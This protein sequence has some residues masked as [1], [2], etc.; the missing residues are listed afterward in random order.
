M[1]LLQRLSVMILVLAV[2]ACGAPLGYETG[3]SISTP[4]P[5]PSVRVPKV[6]QEWVYTE[7][8]VYNGKELAIVT[9]RVSSIGTQITITRTIA[10]GSQL[11]SEIQGP[12]VMIATDPHWS[13]VITY[14]PPI[15]LWPQSLS[16]NWSKQANTK[17]Q[18]A[19]YP[20]NSYNWDLYMSSDG[21]EQI[22]VPA[23]TFSVMK[24]QN[25]IYF[26]NADPNKFDCSRKET[27]WFAPQIGR[28]VAR[29]STGSCITGAEN[30]PIPEN[31]IQW[32]L[33]SYK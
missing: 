16:G 8:N 6:G 2:A 4:N 10:D 27:L 31:N 33:L 26:E 20:S 5:L 21:W 3:N 22:T 15:P 32:Q 18:I 12:W 29:E 1:N 24:F 11:P 19:G 13:K 23:G 14:S 9:E 7:K 25:L 17:Y 30:F 28:W